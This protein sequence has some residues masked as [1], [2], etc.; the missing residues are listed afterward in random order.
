MEPTRGALPSPEWLASPQPARSRFGGTDQRERAARRHSAGPTNPAAGAPAP[1]KP[2]AQRGGR[3]AERRRERGRR[4]YPDRRDGRIAS[5]AS[6]PPFPRRVAVRRPISGRG[7]RRRASPRRKSARSIRAQSSGTAA[8]TASRSPRR[9]AVRLPVSGRDPRRPTG[10]R[11]KSAR[12]IRAQSSG[13]AAA[14]ARRSPRGGAVRLPVSGRGPRRRTAPRRKSARSIRAQSS[15]AASAA[16][17]RSSRGGRSARRRGSVRRQRRAPRRRHRSAPRKDVP[18]PRPP[19]RRWQAQA[20]RRAG[21]RRRSAG[22]P[23]R[24]RVGRRLVRGENGWR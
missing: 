21:A 11:R 12:S 20:Q 8:A 13:A 16:A 15:S 2:T 23:A 22:C 24:R 7:P 17:R 19:G 10:P 3:S 4:D 1:Q 9:I 18:P 14:T 5:A 6:P